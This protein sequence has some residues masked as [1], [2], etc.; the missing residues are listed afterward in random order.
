MIVKSLGKSL[1]FKFFDVMIRRLWAPK[2]R[3][4]IVDLGRDYFI[5]KFSDPE[6]YNKA[7]V[8]GPWFINKSF[9]SVRIWQPNFIA[10]QGF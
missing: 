6:D 5:V 1:G 8:G 2:G 3:L 9:L 10:N 4:D 7:L